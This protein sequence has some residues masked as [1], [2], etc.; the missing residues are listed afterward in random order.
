MSKCVPTAQPLC[1]QVSEWLPEWDDPGYVYEPTL[2]TY[3]NDVAGYWATAF[4]DFEA[5]TR[6][7][8]LLM[9]E[10]GMEADEA[11]EYGVR[12]ARDHGYWPEGYRRQPIEKNNIAQIKAQTR[13]EDIANRVT[14][15]RW[16]GNTGRG[17]CPLHHGDNP[18]SFAVYIDDQHFYCFTCNESGDVITLLQRTGNG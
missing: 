6:H 13:I 5:A 4:K 3:R 11:V 1:Q 10:F 2:P 15:M 12:W 7:W 14:T 18:T 8:A 16:Q 17:K 9:A